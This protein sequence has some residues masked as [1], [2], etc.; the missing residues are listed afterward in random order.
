MSA[1]LRRSFT[2]AGDVQTVFAVL[3][4]ERWAQRRAEVLRDG[5]RVVRREARPD[6][7]VLLVVSREL[8]E[9]VP[10]FLEKFL[11]RDGRACQT[12]EWGPAGA[13]GVRQGT[14]RADIPGAPAKVGG[15]MRLE[16]AGSG[17]TYTVDG[18]VRVRV[19]II[20]GRAESFLAGMLARLTEKEADVLQ[21]MLAR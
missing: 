9:G 10:G 14:W 20:G 15:T 12:D 8:P 19:P 11:P 4:S 17:C 6:G 3:S 5:T 21:G 18:E 7:G 2:L 13:D 16:P 1:A